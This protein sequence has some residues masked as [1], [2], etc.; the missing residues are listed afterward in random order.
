MKEVFHT[1]GAIIWL[2]GGMFFFTLGDN[3]AAGLACIALAE[4]ST[5]R[6]A[7]L[8]K[9]EPE[10]DK[11]VEGLRFL[12]AAGLGPISGIKFLRTS[13]GMSMTEAQRFLHDSE[14]W[15]MAPIKQV[16]DAAERALDSEE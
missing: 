1:I 13:H 6:V 11:R 7:I 5:I 12:K 14:V 2:S 10:I 8:P 16:Q 3:F 15:D 4:I 9:K